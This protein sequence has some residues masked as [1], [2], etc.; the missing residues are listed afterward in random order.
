MAFHK[1]LFL[2]FHVG[3]RLYFPPEWLTQK[4]YFAVAS[5]VW[6][7]GIVLYHMLQGSRPFISDEDIVAAAVIFNIPISTGGIE[8]NIVINSFP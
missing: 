8:L 6:S 2:I 1:G 5:T 4:S 7:V 3:T